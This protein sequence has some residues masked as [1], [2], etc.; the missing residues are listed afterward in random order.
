V[1]ILYIGK[2]THQSKGGDNKMLQDDIKEFNSA[3]KTACHR[4]DDILLSVASYPDQ[5]FPVKSI[6]ISVSRIEHLLAKLSDAMETHQRVHG[7]VPEDLY[8]A[9]NHLQQQL[10]EVI[11]AL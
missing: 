7:G 11:D 10:A 4:A 1:T 8:T 2:K 6:L 5:K 9:V 3:V